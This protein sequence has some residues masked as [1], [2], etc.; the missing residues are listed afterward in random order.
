MI[1]LVDILKRVIPNAEWSLDGD[2]LD[3]L[4]MHDDTPAPTADEIEA[5]RPI[6]QEAK[7]CEA[8]R[9]QRDALLVASDWT[10][11]ADAP[12]D[13]EAWATYRQAL[14]D[15]PASWTPGPTADFPDPPQ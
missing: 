1:T 10:Q 14:R 11:V 2:T 6:V 5:A 13:R 3:G 12:V 9:S 15:F 8:M 4:V 7:W